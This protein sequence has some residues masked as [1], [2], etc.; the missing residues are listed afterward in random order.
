MRNVLLY[1]RIF[2]LQLQKNKTKFYISIDIN[3]TF[4]E[5]KSFKIFK[6]KKN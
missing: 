6:I 5:K 1:S 2:S 4:N 3:G